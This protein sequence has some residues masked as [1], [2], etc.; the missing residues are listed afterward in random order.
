M[1]VRLI[2]EILDHWQD[3]G[4][5]PGERGDLIVLAEN[6]NDS[7]RETWGAVHAPHILKR[8]AKTPASWR[9]SINR[10]MKKKALEFAK[11][12][13][14]EVRGFTGQHAVY[15]IVELCPEPPHSGYKGHCT[16]PVAT[17]DDGAAS[18]AATP[19]GEE[20]VADL[21]PETVSP[22]DA[23]EGY[24]SANAVDEDP[25]EG[26]LTANPEGYLTAN[27]VDGL[28]YLTAT[29]R[30]SG[31][32]TPTPLVSSFDLSSK[33]SPSPSVAE[34]SPV[35]TDAV[36]VA[37]EGGGGGEFSSSEDQEQD[38]P[39]ARAESFVDS[40]DNRGKRLGQT[41]RAKLTIRV[42]A[43]FKDGWTENGLRRYLDISDDP[44]VRTPAAVYAH[45]LSE[46]ELP[47]AAPDAALPPACW[48]C[49]GLSPAAAT[50]LALRINPIT[51]DPCPNCHPASVG[52]SPEVPPVCDACVRENPA[53][54]FNIRFRYRVIDGVHQGCP[55]CH[56]TLVARQATQDGADGGMWD[57]AMDRARQRMQTGDWR[58][59]G[60]DE[61]IAGWAA[62]GNQLSDSP[63]K[64]DQRVHQAVQAGRR[65][66]AA[67][68]R[69]KGR[70]QLGR[71]YSNDVWQ[72]PADPAKA[73]KIPHC[74]DPNC[75][76]VTRLKTEPDW[77]GEP[78]T[79][80]C[81]DCHPGMKF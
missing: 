44:N 56:P 10:L 8:A 26:Y 27:A 19:D 51:C 2:V 23:E 52:Q 40:L 12:D 63:S 57:R 62:V 34:D 54:Q 4:L 66:Q 7:S 78:H 48:D 24:P 61:R 55:D 81:G 53:A 71:N 38:K 80:V 33:D 30:V 75:D 5:T 25:E 59:A 11:R 31:Q 15:R 18:D 45:R 37:E 74:G 6:A 65:L 72:Q 76:P 1:G 73:A 17:P 43:A 46:D 16:K 69:R 14:R 77:T 47:E 9:I 36:T 35:V 58:G 50:D 20:M 49:L 21:P 70:P 68:D 22:T 28:G 29:E 41:R 13:G 39:L 60:P 42:A 79:A 64:T 3:I 67:D 32:L